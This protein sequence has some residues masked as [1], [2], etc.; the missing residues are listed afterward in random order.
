MNLKMV[1]FLGNNRTLS[2]NTSTAIFQPPSMLVQVIMLQT[3]I[4]EMPS[5][6]LCQ[7]TRYS[8]WGFTDK[9]HNNIVGL[10]PRSPIIRSARLNWCHESQ[11]CK[12]ICFCFSLCSSNYTHVTE[13]EVRKFRLHCYECEEMVTCNVATIRTVHFVMC[14][15]HLLGQLVGLMLKVIMQNGTGFMQITPLY[16]ALGHDYLL[17]NSYSLIMLSINTT[18]SNLLTK[19]LTTTTNKHILISNSI[20]NKL[21]H[22]TRDAQSMQCAKSCKC[23]STKYQ[24][25]NLYLLANCQI[26]SVQYPPLNHWG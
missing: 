24:C 6:N 18:E 9:Q 13:K 25:R 3:C 8:D 17:P 26:L 5:L 23:Y 22:Y 12:I 21:H 15:L 19:S 2:C 20:Y 11:G 7:N 4:L 1:H 14:N 16:I 10:L